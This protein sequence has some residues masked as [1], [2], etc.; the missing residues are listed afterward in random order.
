M[1]GTSPQE[2]P[3]AINI[4][5]RLPRM[6]RKAC[7]SLVPQALLTVQRAVTHHMDLPAVHQQSKVTPLPFRAFTFVF[8]C[9]EFSSPESLH[10]W[11]LTLTVSAQKHDILRSPIQKSHT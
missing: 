6:A 3:H 4:Q 9:P 5:S 1:V 7:H 2:P 10:G 11:P 8:P